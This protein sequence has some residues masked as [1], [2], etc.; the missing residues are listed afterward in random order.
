MT[1][2]PSDGV[3]WFPNE[4]RIKPKTPFHSLQGINDPILAISPS[5]SLSSLPPSLCF[6]HT[7][8]LQSLPQNSCAYCS[9]CPESPSPGHPL[10]HPMPNSFSSPKTQLQWH[11][12]E[13]LSLTTYL[14][15]FYLQTVLHFPVSSLWQWSISKIILLICSLTLF[16]SVW[17][18][19]TLLQWG[20]R[21][22]LREKTISVL[23]NYIY[24]PAY[25]LDLAWNQ[26][27]FKWMQESLLQH[28]LH[29]SYN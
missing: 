4:N 9:L 14:F 1:T 15:L 10:V 20:Q 24:S 19:F 21:P 25:C 23:P 28:W 18:P 6:N 13:R 7:P 11:L 2:V 8:F 17:S 29:F 5:S 3:Q 12:L 16:L 22:H 26:L 27:I